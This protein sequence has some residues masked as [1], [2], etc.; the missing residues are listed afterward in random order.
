MVERRAS[1]PRD[2]DGVGVLEELAAGDL[3]VHH[4]EVEA[5]ASV[6]VGDLAG[7]LVAE[8]EVA[9]DKDLGAGL[10]EG[11]RRELPTSNPPNSLS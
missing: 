9:L 1:R 10:G 2:R 11:V 5:G 7:R 3:A 6:A 4:V 8:P